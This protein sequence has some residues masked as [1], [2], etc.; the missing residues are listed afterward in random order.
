MATHPEVLIVG[1]GPAG[2]ACAIKLVRAGV[3]VLVLEGAEFAGAENWS[4]AVYHADSW[5]RDDLIGPALWRDAPKERRVVARQL[6]LHDGHC[7]GGFEARAVAG[8]DFGEAWTVLRPKMDRWLAAR[9]VDFGATLLTRT[10][11]TG[12]RYGGDRVIGVNTNRGPIEADCVFLAEGDAA[13]LIAREGLEQHAHPEYAQGIMAVFALPSDE[14][15]RR[16]ELR[17]E[18]GIAQ[19]WL[20]RNGTLGGKSVALNATA[21]LYT[22]LDSLSVGLVLPLD[23]LATNGVADHPH[24]LKRVLTLPGIAPYLEGARQ[25]AYGAK[26]I[27]AGGVTET[28]VWVRDGLAVGGSAVGMGQEIP[29][30]N[31]IAPAITTGLTFAQAWL[32]LRARQQAP[33]RAALETA[34]A[35]GL[36][37]T[38]DYRNAEMTKHWPRA[39]HGGPLLFETLPALVGQLADAETLPPDEAQA[40]RQ[41]AFAVAMRDLRPVLKQAR[42]FMHGLVARGATSHVSVPPLAV[43]WLIASHGARPREIETPDFALLHLLAHAVGHFYGRRLPRYA[44]RMANVW[45]APGRVA[46]ALLSVGGMGARSARGALRLLSDL[47]AYRWNKLPLAE[48]MNRPY[49]RHE[50]AS[51]LALDWN[52]AKRTA[53]SPVVWIAPLTRY[54]PDTRHISIPLDA[55]ADAARQLRNV[56]PAEVYSI[57][58]IQGGVASQY[59]NCIKCESCRVSVPGVDW[60]RSSSH[61]L[62]YRAPHDGRYGFDAAVQSA[63]ALPPPRPAVPGSKA[64]HELYDWLRARPPMVNT[65]WMATLNS[66]IERLPPD[67]MRA[68]LVRFRE[69]R[70]W[71]WMESELRAML[72]GTDSIRD[73]R[74]AWTPGEHARHKRGLR[75]T[76][77]LAHFDRDRLRALASEGW[78]DADRC[79][80]FA[81]LGV[82]RPHA[83]EAVEWL[84]RQSGSL[85]WLAANHFL[86]EDYAR[87][88]ITDAVA[89]PLWREPDGESNWLPGI[90]SMLV[91]VKGEFADTGQ[92]VAHDLALD[93]AQPVRR[94]CGA[95]VPTLEVPARL[96]E[97]RLAMALGELTALGAR[98]IEFANTRVQFRGDIKDREG[99]DSIAK[100]GAIKNML[101]TIEH[102]RATL[103]AARD[104]CTQAPRAVLERIRTHMGPWMD[105]VPWVAGQ[106]FGGM[107][108]SEEDILAPRYRDAT[109][110][111]QWPGTREPENASATRIEATRDVPPA[112]IALAGFDRWRNDSGALR[113]L[114]V[115]IA[116]LARRRPARGRAMHW[117]AQQKFKYRSGAFITGNLLAPAQL[118]TIE[119]YRRD[120][121]LRKT[122]ADVL[123][124]IRSGFRSP[125]AGEPYGRY[126]DRQHGMPEED[127]ARLRAFNAFATVVPASLGGRSWNKAQYSVLTNELMSRG[128]VSTGLLV[129]A[130]T[131]I[132]TMP[133]LL[134]LDKDLPRLRRELDAC[135]GDNESWNGLRARLESLIAMLV[136]PDPKRFRVAMEALGADMRA[137]FLQPGSTLKYLARGLLLHMQEAAGIARA[138]DLDALE[139]ALHAL[140]NDVDTVHARFL[141]ERAA[142]DTRRDAHTRFLQF[143]G[144][145]QISAF[146]LT[147][148]GA[149]SDTG[150][151]QTRAT[152]REVELVALSDGRYEFTP[153]GGSGGANEARLL[154]DAARFEFTNR[155][156]RYRLDNNT[157]AELD[158]T[159]WDMHANHGVRHLKCGD[160]RLPYHDIGLPLARDG[161]LV[162]RYYEL[163][164]N[165]MWITNGSVADRYA[166]YAR[167]QDGECGV[168]LERRSEGLRIGPNE[169]KL[170]QRASP[171]NEL[172]LDRVRVD[173]SQ[174]IGF[175]GHGQ[176]NALETLSVGRGGLVMSC[177][178]LIGRLLDDFPAVWATHP[179]LAARAQAERDGIETLATRLVGLMDRADLDQGDF[180]IEAAFSKYL[181]SE[182]AHRVLGWIETLMGPAAAAIEQ[183]LEKYRR[184]IRILNIYEG[185]NE[186]QRF[187][188][189]KDLPG[190][191]KEASVAVTDNPPLDAALAVFRD[192]AAPRV[193]AAGRDLLA[194]PDLQTRFFPVVEWAGMLYM[195]CALHERA[196]ALAAGGDPAD[197]DTIARLNDLQSSLATH[198]DDRAR[199]IRDAFRVFDE[200]G[201]HPADHGIALAR[202]A[203]APPAPAS[204]APTRVGALT[205]AFVCILRA[206]MTRRDDRLEFAG[207]HAADIAAL[208][209]VLD[210]RD[211]SPYLAVTIAV[212]APAGVEDKLRALQALGVAVHYLC[213]EMPDAS[214]TQATAQWLQSNPGMP[215]GVV[216]GA[217]AA[218]DADFGIALANALDATLLRDIEALGPARRGLWFENANFDRHY[219]HRRRPIVLSLDLRPSGRSDR[220][221]ARVWLDALRTPLPRVV[222]LIVPPVLAIR[223]VQPAATADLPVQ[224]ETPAQLAQW[225][226]ARLGTASGSASVEP[227]AKLLRGDVSLDDIPVWVAAPAELGQARGSAALR[228][229]HDCGEA[230]AVATWSAA[231]DDAHSISQSL[232]VPG[233]RGIWRI[234]GV[235]PAHLARQLAPML[236]G[237]SA[238]IVS[239]SQRE[240]GAALAGRL[241]IAMFG[242]LLDLSDSRLTCSQGDFVA[243]Y[244]RHGPAVYVAD[245]AYRM[246]TLPEGA[247]RI[248]LHE[249]TANAAHV[250]SLTRFLARAV[251]PAGLGSAPIIVD[252]GLGVGDSARF[253]QW[254]VPL[255][256]RLGEM[257]GR[258]VEI[259]A[260]RRVTQELKLIGADRQIGQTGIA[261]APEV[262]LALGISGAPQ[263]MQWIGKDTIV[264]AINR[265]LTAPIFTWH[266]QNPGPRVIACVGDLEKW[267]PGLLD[268]L[269]W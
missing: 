10:T 153:H 30:P 70:A 241:G 119:H 151:I 98:A 38:D 233:L 230:F 92:I 238:I 81:F 267:I 174:L 114:Q 170:G 242:T 147:E 209:R 183:P 252:A 166:L 58:S 89:A 163:S 138:R 100:F 127:I 208:E 87:R 179:A 36:R 255:A 62:A 249:V 68:Q 257:S 202:R 95:A 132:G 248:G 149:G 225:L 37:A 91:T 239:A 105:A 263:H 210:W 31:F 201:L 19:E 26:V 214:V 34:Y 176:V 237:A 227:A 177:A 8:N 77:L 66:L 218:G 235:Q 24:L 55:G 190:L 213:C 182:G 115:G 142:L 1:A 122:R 189:L 240:L 264:I 47:A 162:Y 244:R 75:Y 224:F 219:C 124:L 72:A 144:T 221:S 160:R 69:R 12:L 191:F 28:P 243:D 199:Q 216:L 228:L 165:K 102:A 211:G 269:K 217:A 260:T 111:A 65:Q 250:S 131:S 18:E 9:A 125:R 139:P 205:G 29:Y 158:D 61:R 20:I 128:D 39:I 207:W 148:P 120:P 40:Q 195:W 4:G 186:V 215:Q 43:R 261:V 15:E 164:G 220:Y 107:A 80:W 79:A 268:C 156:A 198:L 109:L 21:F 204:D 146:A 196:R 73:A 184:D 118:L 84:A 193:Q 27:R 52:T 262:L 256:A 206:A 150:A 175:A 251:Q 35:T 108:F 97:L 48:L 56:C 83:A 113:P 94:A 168:M 99:R 42:G 59:E 130:S 85:A 247:E 188:V 93:A 90:A 180:R 258:R 110:L 157:C 171:T 13:G 88:V 14:I 231:G 194:D 266:Q 116:P 16:F 152:I 121:R 155:H 197:R 67:D 101:A 134:G 49:H 2:I 232:A 57:V 254:V 78:N 223:A 7:A 226:R 136:R 234:S 265:D 32:D 212:L 60:N 129:M 169:N 41:R 123:R 185:T 253:Q 64:I 181:A 96:A 173:A 145:G 74:A 44:D 51:R 6:F 167:A 137:M 143:L 76:Q 23:K 106:I 33:T 246:Y 25:V 103:E 50:R 11:V 126:I 112:D 53:E 200:S 133:V 54:A 141:E 236:R 187:L 117:D 86:G 104:D 71:G 63:I 5:L 82:A 22:N 172:T 17:R 159:D 192:F 3:R 259:G 178:K 229:A 222:P 154:V 245:N 45:R 161:K 135:L 140:R 46:A 203:L